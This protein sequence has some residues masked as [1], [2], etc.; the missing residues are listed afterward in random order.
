MSKLPIVETT[1]HALEQVNPRQRDALGYLFQTFRIRLAD[2]DDTGH[3]VLT[4]LVDHGW[5]LQ[6]GPIVVESRGDLPRHLLVTM[7][8]VDP[9]PPIIRARLDFN[10]SA[11]IRGEFERS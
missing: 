8:L 6:G 9:R 11:E 4:E 5:H 3:A 7:F 1:K 10:G 2:E